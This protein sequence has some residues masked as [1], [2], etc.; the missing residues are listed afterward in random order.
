[1]NSFKQKHSNEKYVFIEK[2]TKNDKTQDVYLGKGMPIIAHTTNKKLNILNSE[3]FI[4]E[5][6]NDKEIE[7]SDENRK[8]KVDLKLFHKLFYLG[9]CITIHA[10]QGETFKEKYTIY[11]WGFEHF[12]SRAKY[13]ALSRASDLSNIQIA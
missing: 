12:C 2:D 3:K 4:I 13:V 8:V 5:T 7:I 6:I 11:D 9:F 10:S 1:M